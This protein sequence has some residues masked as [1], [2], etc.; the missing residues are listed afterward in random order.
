MKGSGNK[1]KCDYMRQKSEKQ[2]VGQ[3][4]GVPILRFKKMEIL[5]AFCG[6]PEVF[7]GFKAIRKRKEKGFCNAFATALQGR[8]SGTIF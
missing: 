3:Y 2:G 5:P 1:W 7:N 6:K 4:S 8:F